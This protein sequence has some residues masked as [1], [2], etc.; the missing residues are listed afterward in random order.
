MNKEIIG[1]IDSFICFLTKYDGK[2]FHNVQALMLGPRFKNLI[3]ISNSF[4][5]HELGVA[6]AKS[7][8]GNLYILYCS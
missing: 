7:L 5:G 2:K 4:I 8:K 1:V 3:L 6:I